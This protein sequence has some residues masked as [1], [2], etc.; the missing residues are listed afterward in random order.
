MRTVDRHLEYTWWK[1][2]ILVLVLVSVLFCSHR[3]LY[4]AQQLISEDSFIFFQ[5]AYNKPFFAS[6]STPYAGYFHVLP[7]LLAELMWTLPFLLIPIVNHI[8]ALLLSTSMLSWFYSPYCRKVIRG[9]GYRF[10]A[11]I[12][13]ALLPFQPNLGMLLGL[14]W[15][16]SFFVGL[17][18]ISD[19]PVQRVKILGLCL[20]LIVGAWSSPMAVIW[21]PLAGYR[22]Y[23]DRKNISR[24]L[25][26]CFVAA[27]VIH[28]I[29]IVAILKPGSSQAE[30]ANVVTAFLA[31]GKVGWDELLRA[32]IFGLPITNSLLRFPFQIFAVI[33]LFSSA[34]LCW[35][36]NIRNDGIAFIAYAGLALFLSMIR[37]H[38][39]EAYLT[40]GISIVRYLT[41]PSLL[42]M[43]ALLIFVDRILSGTQVRFARAENQVFFILFTLVILHVFNLRIPQS[44]TFTETAVAH[45]SK[46]RIFEYFEKR[47]E[48]GGQAETVAFPGWTP[49]EVMRLNIGGGRTCVNPESLECI[50]GQDLEFLGDNNYQV[51]WLGRFSI[52]SGNWIHL[53]D[54]GKVEVVGYSSGYYW[55][56][57]P[58]GDLFLSGPA[59]Y[60]RRFS[61]PIKGFLKYSDPKT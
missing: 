48:N 14:H 32:G 55:F 52:L 57:K 7:M 56:R 35:R 60:P 23:T 29:V 6:L 39:S 11:V 18:L 24:Y 42:L 37:G 13:L 43:T 16:F 5:T 45:E 44:V 30:Y 51:F 61:Y 21:I 58:D 36:R 3:Q 17:L 28:A 40:L 59:I 50:F 49:V 9:D 53:S 41:V 25:C 15:Y 33:G 2:L 19:F 54:W 26:L 10:M 31:C 38:Q 27:T 4:L 1:H 47:F 34:I 8:V 46:V 12:I 20:F 22:Y